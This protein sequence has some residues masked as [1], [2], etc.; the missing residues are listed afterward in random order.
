MG[1]DFIDLALGIMVG[2]CGWLINRL[3]GRV[4]ACEN[5]QAGHAIEIR[6][7]RSAIARIEAKCDLDPYP[8]TT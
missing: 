7:T 8:Y 5:K 6:D 3:V 2:A 1:H 4:D